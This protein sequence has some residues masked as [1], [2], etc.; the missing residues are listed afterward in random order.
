MTLDATKMNLMAT[1]LALMIGGVLALPHPALAEQPCRPEAQKL[2]HGVQP[3]GGR[4]IACLKQHESE[5][6]PQCQKLV[7]QSTPAASPAVV[8]K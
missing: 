7:A 1:A 8:P 6:S 4:I 3:G 2:C 5:L